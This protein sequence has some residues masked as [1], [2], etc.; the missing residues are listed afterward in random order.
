M[1]SRFLTWKE[2][3]VLGGLAVAVLAGA[4]VLLVHA[5][6]DDEPDPIRLRPPQGESAPPAFDVPTTARVL[7]PAP[8]SSTAPPPLP[9]SPQPEMIVAEIKGAVKHPGVFDLPDTARVEDLIEAAGGP[10]E[11][12]DL[13][14]INRAARLLDGTPLII[15]RF[16]HIALVDGVAVNRPELSAAELNP[17]EYTVS[18][19]RRASVPVPPMSLSPQT[20]PGPQVSGPTLID[21]NTATQEQLESLPSI[22][23]VTAQKIIAYRT[24]TPFTCVEDLMNIKGIG[25]KTLEAVRN[26]VTVGRP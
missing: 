7:E 21:L 22:G 12:A 14:D 3:V 4:I 25:P 16:S 13:S 1:V 2:Q 9:S 11:D 24:Q 10:T 17:P 8:A 23:P 15:P 20:L 18:G 19:W 6:R 5:R 26:L